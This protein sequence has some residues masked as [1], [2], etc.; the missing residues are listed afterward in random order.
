MSWS[1]QAEFHS[2]EIFL[3]P[4]KRFHLMP[5]VRMKTDNGHHVTL[6]ANSLKKEF[7]GESM[8]RINLEISKVSEL[9]LPNVE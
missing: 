1:S 9:T 4:V 8:G 2:F 6:N 5:G 3:S 7:G